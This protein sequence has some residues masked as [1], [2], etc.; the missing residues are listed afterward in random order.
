[1][2]AHRIYCYAPQRGVVEDFLKSV[3][4]LITHDCPHAVDSWEQL[5]G[6]EH[7]TFATVDNH[8][9]PVPQPM[10][11]RLT[12]GGAMVIHIDDQYRRARRA[13]RVAIH[14]YGAGNG[15]GARPAAD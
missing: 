9:Q 5:A 4:A 13:P 6:A 1:M 10:W 8:P 14:H 12:Q 7:I 3:G 11:E 2:S 15:E